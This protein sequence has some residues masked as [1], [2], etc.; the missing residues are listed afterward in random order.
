LRRPDRGVDRFLAW[1][2]LALA[3]TFTLYSGQA[4]TS[5]T[6]L[7]G[8][9][10]FPFAA[11]LGVLFVLRW[12][13]MHSVLAEEGRLAGRLPTR[14]LGLCLALS[15]LV[16]IQ[17]SAG[18][19]EL[20]AVSL[21]LVFYGTSLLLNPTTL[22]IMLPYAG[23]CALG[24]TVPAAVQYY[25][26]GPLAG[27]ATFLSAGLVRLGGIPVTWHGTQ[28]E[29]VS[30]AG[31]LVTG[32]VTPGCSSVISVTTFLGLLGLMHFDMK[33]EAS[34]TLKTAAVGVVALVLLNSARIGILIWVGYAD[35]SAALWG[36]HYWIGYALFLGFYL[37]VLVVYSRMGGPRPVGIPSGAPSPGGADVPPGWSGP[38]AVRLLGPRRN[39]TAA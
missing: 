29:L 3:A 16:F 18:S 17:Y 15:P 5:F 21:V 30:K 4:V 38:R 14:M 8:I 28:F 13:D 34:A 32:T 6:L 36:L 27:L 24:V 31:G 2:G 7:E 22:R 1:L 37:V 20:S 23:L 19:Q 10:G 26:G 9:P 12:K 11:L 39:R 25:I 33:K 35:G